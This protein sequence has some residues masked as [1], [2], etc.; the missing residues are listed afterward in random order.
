MALNR[1]LN[2]I[3]L[4]GLTGYDRPSGK[5]N[6]GDAMGMMRLILGFLRAVTTSSIRFNQ[7]MRKDLEPAK[8]GK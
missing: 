4:S 7:E 5:P 2:D 1:K 8:H 3:F 6:G